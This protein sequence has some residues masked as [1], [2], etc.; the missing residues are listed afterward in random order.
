MAGITQPVPEN[1]SNIFLYV[2]TQA[3]LALLE[4]FA[5][6][7]QHPPAFKSYTQPM[8]SNLNFALLG[9]VY[10]AIRGETLE[11]G[12]DK[13]YHKKLN[14]PS[15]TLTHPGPNADTIIPYNDTWAIFS[16]SLGLEDP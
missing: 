7:V 1:V 11:K 12:W 5:G 13:L 10:E 3:D 8:Y 4:Y 14:M 6:L 15:T 2:R 16:Y 9:M